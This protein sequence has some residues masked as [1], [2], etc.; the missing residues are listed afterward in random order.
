MMQ[1]K[2]YKGFLIFETPYHWG[3]E[4]VAIPETGETI[5]LKA[6]DYTKKERLEIIK[7]AINERVT[8]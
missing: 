7:N 4:L 2:T 3:F 6:I 8:L 5:R 1:T